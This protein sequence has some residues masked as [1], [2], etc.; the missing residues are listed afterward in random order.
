MPLTQRGDYNGPVDLRHGMWTGIGIGATGL[1]ALGLIAMYTWSWLAGSGPHPQDLIDNP[2]FRTA[3]FLLWIAVVAGLY[4]LVAP[5]AGL[6]L[7]KTRTEPFWHRP[8]VSKPDP[9]VLVDPPSSDSDPAP[10]RRS[11]LPNISRAGVTMT[12][13]PQAPGSRIY[14]ATLDTSA[15]A[16]QFVPLPFKPTGLGLVQP[17]PLNDH[18]IH[19][20][21]AWNFKDGKVVIHE[22]T[23]TGFSVEVQPSDLVVLVEID[24]YGS[25]VKP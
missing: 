18:V 22:I 14:R 21:D 10:T 1:G 8:V 6:P 13:A 25:P 19:G 11:D 2:A 24:A 20:P 17:P 4:A 5:F 16:G 15:L 7:P 23:D 12:T 3:L 9:P